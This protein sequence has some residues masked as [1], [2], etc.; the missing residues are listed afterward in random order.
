[1]VATDYLIPIKKSTRDRMVTPTIP[2]VNK[3]PIRMPGLFF[4]L[5]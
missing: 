5:R 1:M 4:C 2:A 3:P